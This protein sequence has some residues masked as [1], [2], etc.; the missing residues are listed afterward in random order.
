MHTTSKLSVILLMFSALFGCS[1]PV[2]DMANLEGDLCFLNNYASEYI[3]IVRVKPNG[4]GYTVLLHNNLSPSINIANE[5]PRWSFDKRNILFTSSGRGTAVDNRD[6]YSIG[7]DGNNLV[8][9]TNTPTQDE[10]FGSLSPDG[11]TL[12]F[13]K[14]DGQLYLANVDGSNLRHLT[15]FTH[16]TRTIYASQAIWCHDGRT[17]IF[18]SNKDGEQPNIYS[19]LADGTGLKRI[20][21]SPHEELHPSVT[22]DGRTIAFVS[23]ID[24]TAHIYTI[25]ADGTN[26]QLVV[27][28]PIAFSPAISPDGRHIAFISDKTKTTPYDGEDIYV[29]KADGTNLRRITHTVGSKFQLS[30]K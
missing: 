8:N 18:V 19:I 17:I 30:W 27:K 24:Y 13:N 1:K 12:L 16:P 10:Y 20:T 15:N 22:K 29:I 23:I 25:N 9:L 2:D 28:K 26:K 5:L 6:I 7:A 21:N 14:S 3:Q 11:R 4:I